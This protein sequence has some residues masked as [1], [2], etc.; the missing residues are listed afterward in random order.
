M[1]TLRRPDSIFLL[2]TMLEELCAPS[3]TVLLALERR[4][5]DGAEKFFAAA[6]RAG[7]ASTVLQITGRVLIVEMSRRGTGT[8]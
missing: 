4:D 7:F 3:T 8:E 1:I 5:G 6:E 2:L